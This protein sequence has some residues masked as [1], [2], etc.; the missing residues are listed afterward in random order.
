MAPGNRS[1]RR[2]IAKVRRELQGSVFETPKSKHG[3][4][5]DNDMDGAV[6]AVDPGCWDTD[7]T[8]NGFINDEARALYVPSDDDDDLMDTGAADTGL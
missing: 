7:G 3:R 6:D 2:G 5:I 4:G 1:V 8:P